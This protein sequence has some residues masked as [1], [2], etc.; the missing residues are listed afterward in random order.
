VGNSIVISTLSSYIFS[1]S[2][3]DLQFSGY[4]DFISD[5]RFLHRVTE[6]PALGLNCIP[7]PAAT[8]D[9]NG[10]SQF[11]STTYF[12]ATKVGINK[13]YNTELNGELDVSG[14]IFSENIYINQIGVFG[15]S[16]TAQQFLTPSDERLK[17]NIDTIQNSISSIQ[18][19]RGVTF[20]WR[21]TKLRDIGFIAQEV[22]SVIP[23]AVQK[24]S[25]ESYLVVAYEKIIPV[26]IEGIKQLTERVDNLERIVHSTKK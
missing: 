26:L 8:L 6:K 15:E 7:D 22:S 5:L 12:T 9:V 4:F 14:S 24:H 13:E 20:Q 21:N 17:E 10:L 19:M 1:L 16:V 25:T 18:Q 23:E 3:V 2:T 11:R